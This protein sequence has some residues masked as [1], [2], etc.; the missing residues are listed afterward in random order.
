MAI[1]NVECFQV[2]WPHR[3]GSTPVSAWVRITDSTGAVGI[4]EASP[5][6]DGLCAL[7]IIADHLGPM[8]LGADP[9]ETALLQ[10]RLFHAAIKL[11]PDGALASAL[12]AIDI[13]L[14]DLKGHRLG[15]PVHKLM[16]GA[17]RRTIPFYSSVG[18]TADLSTDEAMARVSA[19]LAA[20]GSC[21]VKLRISGDR[22]VRD[23]HIEA[24]IAKAKALR[25]LVGPSFALA[26]D[27]N[28]GYSPGGAIRLGRAL[29]E[30]GYCWFEEP[31]QHYHEKMMGEV[32]GRLDIPVAAG[33]QTYTLAG[34]ARLIEAG[35]RVLQ[36]DIVK[37]G[38]F[39]GLQQVLALA[40]AHGVDVAQHQTQP[41]IGQTA[42]LHVAAVQLH[43]WAPVELNDASGHQ[44]QVF[45]KVPLP[46][47]G[48]FELDD[49]P[50][51]G[52]TLDEAAL[53]PLK[54]P[55]PAS[56]A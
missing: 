23:A 34:F 20:D 10:E 35:V 3:P 18:H 51:L 1:E 11:G 24:D 42:C 44:T 6:F 27:G 46:T 7:R 8:L 29:E 30:L 54:H 37:M 39:T 52:I 25:D 50:G 56:A 55:V 28:S 33:E 16:G 14:W 12:A 41:A 15:L 43:G 47:N 36:P 21:M 26:F 4:G 40:H 2:K 53:A 31:V 48:I 49:A 13:A 45:S 17:W 9:I 22:T 38:G 32:A 19:R 5:M